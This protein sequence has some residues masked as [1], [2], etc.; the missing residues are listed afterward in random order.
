MN[1]QELTILIGA[2]DVGSIIISSDSAEGWEIWAYDPFDFEA[3]TVAGFGNRL[4]TSS[5]GKQPKLYTSL[6]RAYIALKK[7]GWNKPV[8]IEER[9][10]SA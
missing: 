4:T 1:Q 7:L 8:T 9:F 2:G 10:A 5:R 6:D 3:N